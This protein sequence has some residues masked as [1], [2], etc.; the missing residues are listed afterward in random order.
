MALWIALYLAGLS[1]FFTGVSGISENL[2]RM[3]GQQFRK[4]L[5]RSTHHPVVAGL[6]GVVLGALTQ[7]TS[8]V[9]FILGGMSASGLLPMS[10]ALMV[11]SFANLGTAVL[12][13]IA[14]LDLHVPILYLVGISGLILA[15]QLFQ[16]W[17]PA[18][19]GLLSLGLVFFGLDMMK[20][21][22]KPMSSTQGFAEVGKFF[23]YWPDAAFFLGMFARIFVHS[24]SALAAIAVT[25]TKGGMVDEFPSML[26]LAGLG[27]G[28]A[29]ATYLL[30]SNLR[31]IPRQIALYQAVTNV[32]AGTLLGGLLVFEHM[33]HV[34]LLMALF[35]HATKSPAGR[36]ADMYFMFNMAILLVSLASL[37]WAPAWLQKMCP[38]TPEQDLSRPMYIHTEALFSPETALDL[39]ELE[40]RRML[41]TLGRYLTIARGDSNDDLHGLHEA[42]I[43]LGGEIET[44]LDALVTEPAAADISQRVISFQRKQETLR[45]LEE[46]VFLFADTLRSHAGDD[47]LAGRLIEAMD[48]IVLTAD[49]ALRS[50][51]AFDMD[52]LVRMT[53]DRGSLMERLRKQ[54][55]PE[56]GESVETIAALHYATTLFERN[57]WLLR[58]IAVWLREDRAVMTQN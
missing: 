45:A 58:Q 13:F 44:F 34:P 42:S 38:P 37:R 26:S 18:F 52:T 7:S 21:V 53:D 50:R 32:G 27:M 5:A 20:E 9:A 48:T 19:G 28:T 24:S 51:D 47:K 46:N 57:V 35:N 49:D 25:A 15:F 33:S 11:L 36:T 54:A 41:T 2:R 12:V 29:I 40:Q 43:I 30:A 4:L 14:T 55:K 6:L 17:R 22:F 10:R 31:G 1:F 16:R 23:D 39:V 56:D 3:S 8:V